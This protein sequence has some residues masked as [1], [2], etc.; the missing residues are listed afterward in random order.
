MSI[1]NLSDFSKF[2]TIFSI[3]P[4]FPPHDRKSDYGPASSLYNVRSSYTNVHTSGSKFN[5]RRVPNCFTTHTRGI[6]GVVGQRI[7][8]Y[9]AAGTSVLRSVPP[10]TEALR[11]FLGLFY[12][13]RGLGVNRGTAP[14]SRALLHNPRPGSC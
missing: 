3:A 2:K 14:L 6:L 1:S 9:Y 5:C 7:A 13:T 4:S 12:I 11:H 10:V 8:P